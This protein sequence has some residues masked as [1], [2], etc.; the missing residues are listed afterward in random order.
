MKGDIRADH[1]P[2]NKW[3]M[4]ILGMPPLTIVEQSGIEEEL[5]TTE[6]PDKTR[7][8]GGNTMPVE[9]TARMPM[10]HLEEQAAM[11]LWFSDSQDPVASNYK[12]NATVIYKSISGNVLR[13]YS[14]VGVFPTKRV[15]PDL[16]M[17]NEG[18][19]ALVEWTFSA[20]LPLPI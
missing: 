3:S 16:D 20:D 17:A 9:F 7:V 18:E 19:L 5:Q 14:L 2:V 8:S 13:T 10:H 12:K 4:I 15:L 11:E 6:L 1:I